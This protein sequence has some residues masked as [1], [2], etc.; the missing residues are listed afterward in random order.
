M[1]WDYPDRCFL[2]LCE[3]CHSE[4]ER[5]LV[6][7]DNTLINYLRTFGL[8]TFDMALVYYSY[9][10]ISRFPISETIA[11]STLINNIAELSQSDRLA[12]TQIVEGL[13][14]KGNG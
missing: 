1:A 3:E 7:M 9:K 4:E 8:D 5:L 14:T 6:H 13:K 12:I 10:S 11:F 2:T